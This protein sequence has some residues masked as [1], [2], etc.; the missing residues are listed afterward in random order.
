LEIVELKEQAEKALDQERSRM[1]SLL[2]QLKAKGIDPE[3]F[4]L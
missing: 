4:E 2:E 3:D 1:Q